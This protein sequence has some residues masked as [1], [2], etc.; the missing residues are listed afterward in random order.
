MTSLT[1]RN[2]GQICSFRL[3]LPAHAH[4]FKDVFFGGFDFRE[5]KKGLYFNNKSAQSSK[6]CTTISNTYDLMEV[7]DIGTQEQKLVL[8]FF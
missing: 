1:L 3:M 2:S 5:D 8:E 6:G 7:T 4:C